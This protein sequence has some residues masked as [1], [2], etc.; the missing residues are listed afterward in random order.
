M[1]EVARWLVHDGARDESEVKYD[2]D[3]EI[4]SERARER[5]REMRNLI[6]YRQAQRY[7]NS[8]EGLSTTAYT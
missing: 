4:E 2:V 1:Q 3:R 5:D 6:L 7:T 8:P